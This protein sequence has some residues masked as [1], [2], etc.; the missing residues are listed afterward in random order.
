ML[1]SSA[2]VTLKRHPKRRQ[3]DTSQER[4]ETRRQGD[5]SQE[6]RRHLTEDKETGHQEGE[7]DTE[8]PQKTQ[9]GE[10]R[11]HLT[12]GKDIRRHLTRQHKGHIKG[13]P[14]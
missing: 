2:K 11:R 10:T 4:K 7:G 8:T 5:T 3:G 14:T 9:R 12:R 6:T 13:C 1:L